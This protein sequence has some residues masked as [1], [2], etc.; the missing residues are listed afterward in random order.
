VIALSASAPSPRAPAPRTR[1]RR[2][3]TC[4]AVA[5][6]GTTGAA[7]PG[8]C[9]RALRR[10]PGA[11]VGHVGVVGVEAVGRELQS[12]RGVGSA[13]GRTL[14]RVG[15]CAIRGRSGRRQP[16][17]RP[18]MS[19][20]TPEGRREDDGAAS[21]DTWTSVVRGG[22]RRRRRSRG[23][24]LDDEAGSLRDGARISP[25]GPSRGGAATCVA[26][27]TARAVAQASARRVR[28]EGH[29][30]TPGDRGPRSLWSITSRTM[31]RSDGLHIARDGTPW[32]APGTPLIR[33]GD[34]VS[35]R[36]GAS[37]CARSATPTRSCRRL[38]ESR[39]G[40]PG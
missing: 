29:D 18:E 3:Q 26:P 20:R 2:R 35:G 14:T 6:V 1:S 16:A 19:H 24:A 25:A 9:S 36:S 38:A 39:R 13:A 28:A 31:A 27:R 10:R 15:G 32:Y 33:S 11:V 8:A 34:D 40:R 22:A 21:P 17:A 7:P 37:R 4:T 12:G 5:Q 23:E 30:G